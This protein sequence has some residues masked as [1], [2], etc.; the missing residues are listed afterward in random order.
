VD[1]NLL[2]DVTSQALAGAM[3]GGAA[4]QAALANNIANVDTPGYVRSDVDFQQTLSAA[5]DRAQHASTRSADLFDRLSTTPQK[6][7]ASPS[8]AD[9]NNVSIDHEMSEMAENALRFQAAGEA[10][11]VRMRMLRTAMK[12]GG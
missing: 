10:L 11:S 6:D 2:S 12:Q 7:Y 8:R 5:L 4:R 3:R 9:G 1:W